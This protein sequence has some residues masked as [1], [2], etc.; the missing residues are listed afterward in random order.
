[1]TTRT[2]RTIGI[3]EPPSRRKSVFNRER[4]ETE[5]VSVKRLAVSVLFVTSTAVSASMTSV[6]IGTGMPGPI[7]NCRK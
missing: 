2:T 1:M 7:I 5:N 3:C 6:G 4:L